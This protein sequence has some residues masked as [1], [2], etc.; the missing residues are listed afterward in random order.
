MAV[1]NT[2]QHPNQLSR[3]YPKVITF[4]GGA[5]LVGSTIYYLAYPQ[6]TLTAQ[7]GASLGVVLLLVVILLKPG[8]VH[9]L[10][11]RRSDNT[12]DALVMCLAFAGI[13]L[14]IYFLSFKYDYELDLTE[15]GEYT[16]SRQTMKVLENLTEPVQVIGFFRA[17]DRRWTEARKYLERYAHYSNLLTYKLYDPLSETSLVKKYK[18]NSYGLLFVNGSHRYTTPGVDE[19][20][21]TTG[22]MCVTTHLHHTSSQPLISVEPKNPP[23]RI[24]ELT[25]FQMIFTFVITVILIPAAALTAGARMWWMRR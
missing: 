8:V 11:T 15:T 21:I 19:A 2:S 14:V 17:G 5:I 24:L 12:A 10:I 7:F 3:M 16:L 20:T 1:D 6:R 18:V 13:L 9:T 22:V 25:P 4:A 23:H